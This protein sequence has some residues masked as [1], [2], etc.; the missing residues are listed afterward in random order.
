[1][2]TRDGA[3]SEADMTLELT[4]Y[5]AAA[6]EVDSLAQTIEDCTVRR[7]TTTSVRR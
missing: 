3:M 1:M 7:R 6:T 5:V 2:L 4:P